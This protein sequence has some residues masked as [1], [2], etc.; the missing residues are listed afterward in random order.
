LLFLYNSGARASEAATLRIADIDWHAPSARF[1]GKGNKQRICP[2]W[3]TT[4]EQ[5]YRITALGRGPE[6]YVFLN[7]NGQPITRFGIHTLVER[8]ALSAAEQAPSLSTKRVS[9]H[10]IRHYL[11]FLTMSGN[12][13][14]AACLLGDC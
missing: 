1:I 9:P 4:M 14:A 2:L 12:P 3:A 5:L 6:Q 10:V 11:P 13:K 8:H 7:R